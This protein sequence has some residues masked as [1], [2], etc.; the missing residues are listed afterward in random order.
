MDYEKATDQ[1]IEEEFKKILF[2]LEIEYIE[3]KE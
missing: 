2:E 1:E 3:E